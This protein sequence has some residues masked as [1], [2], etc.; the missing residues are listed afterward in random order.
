MINVQLRDDKNL[1]LDSMK[2]ES[3]ETMHYREDIFQE[4][5]SKQ[6]MEITNKNFK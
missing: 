1:K 5:E 3:K 4:T 2:T 6:M